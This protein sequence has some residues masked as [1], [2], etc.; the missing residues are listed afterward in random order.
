MKITGN[1]K[2]A[3]Y[4][5]WSEEYMKEAE[6]LKERVRDIRE[7]AKKE[8][9]REAS[10]MLAW[11]IALLYGMYLDC[12]HVGRVLAER[13]Y[14]AKDKEDAHSMLKDKIGFSYDMYKTANKKNVSGTERKGAG[15]A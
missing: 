3:Q 1:M 13:A 9:N 10:D 11:R 4:K 8:K 2:E 14:S 15:A 12:L 6:R 5:G 7:Q